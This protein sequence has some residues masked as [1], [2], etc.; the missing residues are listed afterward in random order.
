MTLNQQKFAIGAFSFIFGIL[1][2][3]G[4]LMI[5]KPAEVRHEYVITYNGNHYFTYYYAKKDDCL[6]FNDTLF[7]EMTLC[8]DYTIRSHA[9]PPSAA[10]Y[11]ITKAKENLKY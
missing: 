8:G 3:F 9:L 1:F 4:V 5:T 2:L 6:Y 10:D 7:D 11:A